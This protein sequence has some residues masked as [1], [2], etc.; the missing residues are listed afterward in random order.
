[1]GR[2]V[3]IECSQSVHSIV[4]G[5]MPGDIVREAIQESWIDHQF[6]LLSYLPPVK[7]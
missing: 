1:M 3:T 6:N 7:K 4:G 5:Y 2:I